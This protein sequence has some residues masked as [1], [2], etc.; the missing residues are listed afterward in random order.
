MFNKT[1]SIIGGTGHVGLPLGLMFAE[2]KYKVQLI[3]IDIKN[4]NKVNK[5]IMPFKED[6]A[7]IILKN[8]IKKKKI[9]ATN[10]LELVK[11]SK[12]IVICIGTPVNKK[13]QPETKNFLSFFK[14][15]K[16]NLSKNSIIIIRSSVYPGICDKVYDICKNKN[17]N[18]SY[19]PERIVQGKSLIELPKLPQII[20][21][22][23][24]KSIDESKNLFSK[25][26]KKI[27]ITTVIEAELIK[28]F[29]NSYR[30]IMFSISNQFFKIC[31]DLNIN[32]EKLR[33][34]MIDGYERNSG[35][36]KPGFTAGPCLLKDTM[37]LSSFLKS[38]FHLGYS[39]MGINESIPIYLVKNLEKKYN[40]KNKTVGV[41][42]MAFKAETDDI[43]D[44]LSIK[45]INY[46]KKKGVKYLY[47]DPYY[48][49]KKIT[50]EK[51]LV[52]NSDFIIV[53][54]PH[55]KYKK[56]KIPKKKKVIDIWNILPK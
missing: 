53:T 23:T 36:A 51:N 45:L 32:F 50:S 16:K 15:L 5:G 47:S 13:L 1:I 3:D 33:L 38:R 4:I 9:F 44:S 17:N 55:K 21:G 42:G 27:I 43:R 40:L 22:F 7:N 24:K 46:L 48:K 26:S 52:K 19:C 12:Y 41:L 10:N 30:Y 6:R 34:N 20:S 31:N 56:I 29:S 35:I 11:L 14:N 8:Q 49:D 37:Q 18:I 39:A 28:L 25:I 2:K 54:V